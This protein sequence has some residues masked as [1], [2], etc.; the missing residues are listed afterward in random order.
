MHPPKRA[1]A[2][3]RWF[4][5]EDSIEEI[6]GDLTEIF[7]KEYQRSPRLSRWKFTWRVIKY[8][9]PEFMKPLKSYYQ[10]NAWGIYK[11]YFKVGW[12]NLIKNRA[13]STINLIGLTVG[14]SICFTLLTIVSHELRFDRF[15]PSAGKIY[16]ILGELTESTG[17]K[18]TFC[19]VPYPAIHLL[20]EVSSVET[21]SAVTP[22]NAQ[23]RIYGNDGSLKEFSSR[24]PDYHFITTAIVEP[25]YFRLFKYD[26]LAG[27]QSTA[28]TAPN[29]VV[30]T[31]S[32]A[33]LY[34][35]ELAP[36]DILG[37]SIVY[38]DSLVAEVTGI[39][40]DFEDNSDLKF[41]DFISG[42]SL[43]NRTLKKH[44]DTKAWTVPTMRTWIFFK[45]SDPANAQDVTRQLNDLLA[46]NKH[47]DLKLALH[48]EPITSMH[49]N[50]EIIENPVRTSHLPTLYALMIIGGLILVL[51]V[52]N[53]VNLN[54]AIYLKRLK[55]AALRKIVGSS[56]GGLVVRFLSENVIILLFASAL[57]LVSIGPLL[58]IFKSYVPTGISGHLFRM[59]SLLWTG[60]VFI[61]VTTVLAAVCSRMLVNVQPVQGINNKM[62]GGSQSFTQKVLIVFQFSISV[63][64]IIGSLVI[65]RQMEF[66]RSKDL[67]FQTNAIVT[68]RAPKGEAKKLKTFASEAQRSGYVTGAAL[69]WQSPIHENPR[70]MKLKLNV[71][72]ASDFGV[73]QIAGD[74][75]YIPLYGIRL[76]AGRNLAPTDTV[77]EL[78]INELLMR[79][80]GIQTPA[81]ALGK[82]LYWNDIPYPVVGVVA[83]FHTL[84]LHQSTGPLCIINRADR[85]GEIAIKLKGS[86]VSD[87]KTGVQQVEKAW[88]A[89]FGPADF[90]VRF[91][92]DSIAQLYLKE[93]ET[94]TL[95]N[96][97]TAIAVLISCI[98]LFG[99]MA[100]MVEGRVKEVGIRKVLGA[101]VTG[102]ISL[103]LKDFITL[104]LISVVVAA[105]IAYY[106]MDR[107][108]HEFA[109]HIQ[110]EWWL[111]IVAGLLA[112]I[113]S[114]ATVSIQT[115]KA[116]IANPV[117]SLRSE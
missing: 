32:R 103:F 9:R 19:R 94:A 89:V 58:D 1:I 23:V 52:T 66:I 74:E 39:V 88:H 101:S 80:I 35:N 56:R 36:H 49:F 16:R 114:I 20:R 93:K 27:D 97:S 87:L 85:H 15:H 5:R 98:G 105:P 3:L 7:G 13:F 28:L 29:T 54:T 12:R 78:V 60:L 55:E 40:R 53:F 21:A 17:D 82:T 90:D 61:S 10:Q 42:S 109:Y 104:V 69:Q 4:C 37:K 81:D 34:F 115:I 31:E 41:S 108:L 67:G 100:F 14:L 46:V 95:M 84:N 8:F 73:T 96:I 59:E 71:S 75:N 102:I 30:I 44:F 51:A 70:G 106:W 83:D 50:S 110:L 24:L 86:S 112:V 26:W 77:K 76:L 63:A 57:A 43:D 38:D 117:K 25:T 91:L 18:L 107:W 45:L 68:L 48:A 113:L 2:F 6:E 64:F 116:A 22:F 11:S 33:R 47:D 92:D 79:K 72:D 111:F 62:R 99:L 65:A